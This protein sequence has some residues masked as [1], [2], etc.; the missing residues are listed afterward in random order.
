MPQAANDDLESSARTDKIAIMAESLREN[1]GVE[2]CVVIE[3]QIAAAA[4]DSVRAT[5]VAI[6]DLLCSPTAHH[7]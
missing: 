4:D 7:A 5:W 6:W 3:R 2:V 1:F